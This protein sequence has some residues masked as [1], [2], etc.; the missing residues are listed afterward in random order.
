MDHDP[1]LA[2]NRPV[3]ASAITRLHSSRP[4]F[5]IVVLAGL[6]ASLSRR[7]LTRRSVP[8]D[9]EKTSEPFPY[10]REEL[11]MHLPTHSMSNTGSSAT[12]K[13]R[14]CFCP[15]IPPLV[16]RIL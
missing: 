10:P 3:S 1:V 4:I 6:E 12:A 2:V 9:G 15:S 13:V 14:K 5:V 7:A 8:H 11:D 16:G